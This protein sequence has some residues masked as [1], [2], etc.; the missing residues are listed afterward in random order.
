M[1]IKMPLCPLRDMKKLRLKNHRD[2]SVAYE[3]ARDLFLPANRPKWGLTTTPTPRM[4]HE[5]CAISRPP[6]LSIGASLASF[7]GEMSFRRL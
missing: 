7:S 6:I 4:R 2:R 3:Q 5:W 1:L